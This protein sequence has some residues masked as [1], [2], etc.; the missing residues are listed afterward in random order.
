MP[1]R[2]VRREPARRHPPP[3]SPPPPPFSSAYIR[4]NEPAYPNYGNGGL[5][6]QNEG[7]RN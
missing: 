2:D 5:G 1:E 3:P 4:N 6:N 7:N